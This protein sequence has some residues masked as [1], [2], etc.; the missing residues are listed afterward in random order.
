MTPYLYL[1][2]AATHAPLGSWGDTST[3]YGWPAVGFWTHFLR[4]EYGTFALYSGDEGKNNTLWLA[5][6]KYGQNAMK[7]ALMVPSAACLYAQH[8]LPGPDKRVWRLAARVGGAAWRWVLAQTER[9]SGAE[10]WDGRAH[11]LC[12]LHVGVP[13][14]GQPAVGQAVG[15]I[16]LFGFLALGTTPALAAYARATR[17]PVLTYPNVLPGIEA[18]L[19][20]LGLW[21][22]PRIVLRTRYA[23]SGI[24]VGIAVAFL[25]DVWY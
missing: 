15:H 14:A 6:V 17:C 2:W 1:F 4:K 16:V 20:L 10:L 23:M 18:L 9:D 19:S 24:D 25:C 22:R 3:L 7:D 12:V 8:A 13:R 5:A 21:Y 11:V